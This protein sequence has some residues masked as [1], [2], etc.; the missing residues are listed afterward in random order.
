MNRLLCSKSL[1]LAIGAALASGFNFYS[2]IFLPTFVGTSNLE[3]FV[4]A[5][6]LGGLYLFSVGSSIAPFSAYVFMNGKGNALLR[7]TMISLI[8]FALVGVGGIGLVRTSMSLVCLGA[9]FCMQIAGFFLASLIRQEKIF[10]ASALKILK[11]ML[12][13]ALLTLYEF[14]DLSKF[15]WPF[16]YSLSCFVCVAV[17]AFFAD[18]KWLIENLSEST[19]EVTSWNSILARVVITSSFPPFLSIRIN[20]CW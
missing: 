18:W 2:F 10:S 15:N 8:C 16:S 4:R 19:F 5:N 14:G 9:A 6:Y 7:Y 20:S 17:M 13:A 1:M 3:E 11:P 12:F